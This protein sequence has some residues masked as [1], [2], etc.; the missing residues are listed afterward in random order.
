MAKV[1]IAGPREHVPKGLHNR[2]EIEIRCADCKVG[3]MKILVTRN[4]EDL[5]ALGSPA[6][7]TQVKCNCRLCGGSSWVRTVEGT[8]HTGA[9]DD[10]C[11]FEPIESGNPNLLMFQAWGRQ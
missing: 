2:E 8:F 5:K 4:N 7:T 11:V 9:F 3:L 1:E 10:E 6:V